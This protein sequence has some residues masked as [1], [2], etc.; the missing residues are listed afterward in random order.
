MLLL[1]FY[2]QVI[3][4]IFR[5]PTPE[6]DLLLENIKWPTA[7]NSLNSSGLTYLNIDKHLTVQN[8]PEE[9]FMSAWQNWYDQYGRPP[10][11]TY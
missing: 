7:R 1:I 11:D 2:Y 3:K 5:N 6:N 10:Y 9:N 4:T 8:N